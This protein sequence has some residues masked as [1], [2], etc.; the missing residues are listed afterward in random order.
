MAQPL[1]LDSQE[2][3]EKGQGTR[4]G[5]LTCLQD[6]LAEPHD[7]T[8]SHH[9]SWGAQFGRA[10]CLGSAS[11]MPACRVG[12]W[13]VLSTTAQRVSPDPP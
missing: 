1:R 11:R 8:R 12:C 4:G 2:R 6:I 7:L 10:A 13:R 3:E 9:R 5:V